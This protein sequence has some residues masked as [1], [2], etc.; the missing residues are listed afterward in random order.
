[1][2]PLFAVAMPTDGHRHSK[3]RAP[4]SR[5]TVPMSMPAISLSLEAQVL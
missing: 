4:R 5:S 3:R 1:M 2:P